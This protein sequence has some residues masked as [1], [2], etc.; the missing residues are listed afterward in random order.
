MELLPKMTRLFFDPD[1]KYKN[2]G[3]DGNVVPVIFDENDNG[4]VD[5][6]DFVRI[7]FGMRRGGNRYYAIDVTNKNSP[8][9]LWSVSP[10][11]V[12][13]TWSTPVVAKID[14]P[15]V[16]NNK[17]VVVIG[18]GYDPVHD[19]NGHPGIDDA[20]GAAVIMLD[21]DTGAELW[22]AARNAGAGNLS[23]TTMKRSI[24]GEIRVIDISGD[25]LADRMYAAD[26]GGQV[27]RFDIFNGVTGSGFV[28]GGVIAQ[29]GAE[30][31]SGTPP[32]T[33]T[34][35]FYASPDVSLFN[36][37]VLDRR[38]LAISLGSGYRAH[39][40]D[41]INTDRFYSLRDKDVFKQLTQN[42]Y[43][44]Y[45]IITEA[46][47][48]E[49]SGTKQA[50]L[51]VNDKGWMFTLPYNQKVLSDSITFNDSIFF[52][53]FSPEFN[54]ANSCVAGA[55]TNYLYE[56]NVKN[57]DPVVD[58]LSTLLP[59]DAD[60]ARRTRLQQGGI[61]PTPTVLFPSPDSTTCT[62]AACSPPPIG[63]VGVECFDPGFENNPVRTLWTQDGIQ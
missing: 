26:M 17:A 11:E 63:C 50:Q 23:L 33:E 39:P 62:G 59:A 53:A 40:L 18:G 7:I 14:A 42:E 41:N 61:A 8:Q 4:L 25:G 29:L 16:N 12:G 51:N 6:N 57:G 21:L 37:E 46:N 3:L 31:L 43:N 34:R 58:N 48:V 56:V 55:G 49:V 9:M 60:D 1:S 32:I 27:L 47:L 24:P 13:Q 10:P 28:T 52:V 36:D 38:F 54:T 30:G 19:T 15:G 5:G 45:T 2:Y 22:R 44:N 35:R 20:T